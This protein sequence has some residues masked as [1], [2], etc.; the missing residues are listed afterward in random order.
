MDFTT[1]HV[2]PYSL[3]Q[4]RDKDQGPKISGASV[5]NN[6]DHQLKL[7]EMMVPTQSLSPQSL[8]L[9]ELQ[10][11]VIFKPPALD[12]VVQSLISALTPSDRKYVWIV[13]Q[14]ARRYLYYHPY[15]ATAMVVCI[16]NANLQKAKDLVDE[17]LSTKDLV[18]RSVL[19]KPGNVWDIITPTGFNIHLICGRVRDSLTLFRMTGST[20]NQIA[21]DC[22]RRFFMSNRCRE[23]MSDLVDEREL[24]WGHIQYALRE[25]LDETRIIP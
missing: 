10:P 5:I 8:S 9:L 6:N 22:R 1:E 17:I 25:S 20:H 21:M 18:T 11:A 3:D 13:G 15:P 12:S 16:I 7:P 14:A 2:M 24:D 4:T 23:L 19:N